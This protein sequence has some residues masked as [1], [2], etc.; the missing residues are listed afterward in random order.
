[1]DRRERDL[2]AGARGRRRRR[3]RA[4]RPRQARRAAPQRHL[5]ATRPGSPRLEA[6]GPPRRGPPPNGRLLPLRRVVDRGRPVP[7]AP[8]AFA[9]ALAP[10]LVRGAE[11]RADLFY[12]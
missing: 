11:E 4:P 10:G 8:V 2:P 12:I 7:V 3:P 6:R 1:R 5:P 9:R